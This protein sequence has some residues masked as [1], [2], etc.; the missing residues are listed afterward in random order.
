MH[1]S[2]DL[3]IINLIEL[4]CCYFPIRNVELGENLSPDETHRSG[5][6]AA[7][8]CWYT[9]IAAVDIDYLLKSSL[10]DVDPAV[11][12]SCDQSRPHA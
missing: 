9:R 4:F 10:Q 5:A 12:L 1:H 7:T 8:V 6:L 3:I 11:Q 2:Y